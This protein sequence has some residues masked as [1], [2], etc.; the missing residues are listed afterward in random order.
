MTEEEDA[1]EAEAEAEAVV[2]IDVIEDVLP[3]VAHHPTPEEGK[4]EMDIAEEEDPALQG[5]PSLDLVQIIEIKRGARRTR[6]EAK[7]KKRRSRKALKRSRKMESVLRMMIINQN[8]SQSQ[9][10]D[11]D[12]DQSLNRNLS[13]NHAQDLEVNSYELEN[14]GTINNTG[15]GYDF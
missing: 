4:I 6:K 11:Q 7:K 2:V 9:N 14:G 12:Q 10:P 13:Q 5:A 8:Q 3:A 15:E 1:V